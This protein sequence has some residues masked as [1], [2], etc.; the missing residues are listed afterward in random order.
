MYFDENLILDIR[1]NTLKDHVDE[2]VIVEDG[3][4]DGTKELIIELEKNFTIVNLSSKKK[5]GYSQAVLDGDRG[6]LSL[7]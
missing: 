4:S 3:S 2:F 5:R 1:L 6:R 7:L